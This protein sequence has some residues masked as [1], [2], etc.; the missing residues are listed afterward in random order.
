[1][2]PSNSS[3]Y[4]LPATPRLSCYGRTPFLSCLVCPRAGTPASG[5][6]AAVPALACGANAGSEDSAATIRPQLARQLLLA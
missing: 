6:A 1:M 3:Y 2:L 4:S 5:F